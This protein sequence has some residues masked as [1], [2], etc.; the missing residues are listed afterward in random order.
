MIRNKNVK[1]VLCAF[2][3][4][5]V[6]GT[7]ATVALAFSYATSNNFY[8]GPINGYSY[9]SFA[10]VFNNNGNASAGTTV[11]LDSGGDQVPIGY[12]GLKCRLYN[13]DGDLV[14]Q[15][16]WVFNSDPC[17]SMGTGTNSTNISNYYYSQGRTAAYNGNG[18]TYYD[19]YQSP[20]ISI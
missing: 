4:S 15:T 9:Y 14:Q 19:T 6:L 17:A 5:F 13:A 16:S 10:T 7:S 1:I 3:I 8:Y 18:Y 2:L 12:M 11:T 20:F